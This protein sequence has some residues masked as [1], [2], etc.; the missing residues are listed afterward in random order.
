MNVLFKA[1]NPSEGYVLQ[2]IL[3]DIALFTKAI[4]NALVRGMSIIEKISG[5]TPVGSRTKHM[6][7]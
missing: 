1:E 4:R 2:E 3:E 7:C 5:G 6:R